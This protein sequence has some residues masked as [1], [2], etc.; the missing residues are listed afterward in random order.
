MCMLK[1]LN[2]VPMWNCSSCPSLASA[3]STELAEFVDDA[4]L[5]C[6]PDMVSDGE[7]RL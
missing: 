7:E 2:S 3:D 4:L 6:L 1:E 5:L